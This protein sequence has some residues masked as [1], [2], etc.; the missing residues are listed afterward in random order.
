[1]SN[2][3]QPTQIE[4]MG[5]IVVIGM[6]VF[7]IIAPM[8]IEFIKFLVIVGVIGGIGYVAFKILHDPLWTERFERW[9]NLG[10]EENE[11]N[12]P[13]SEYEQAALQSPKIDQLSQ[14]LNQVKDQVLDLN[15]ENERLKGREKEI[16]RETLDTYGKQIVQQQGQ[17]ILNDLFGDTAPDRYDRSTEHEKQEYLQRRKQEEEELS[18]QR[19]ELNFDRKLHDL[20]QDVYQR[21]Q[22][23]QEEVYALRQVV[24]DGF[25]A[26]AR[27]FLGIQQEI[28]SLKGYVTEKFAQF[29][30]MLVREIMSVKELVVGLELRVNNE[31]GN[32]KVQ[33]GRE[34]VRLDQQQLQMLGKLQQFNTTVDSFR[35]DM[36]RLRM[37]AERFEM[38][39]QDMLNKVITVNERH[40]A[41]M[42]V[43]SNE[44]AVGLQKM[45]LHDQHFAAKVGQA[46]VMLQEKSNDITFALKDMAYE[47]I[48]INALRDDYQSRDALAQE[49][50]A[51]KQ[52]EISNIRQTIQLEQ[53]H[54]RDT[55]QLQHRLNMASQQQSHLQ[56]MASMMQ[57]EHSIIRRLS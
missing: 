28:T 1:M 13:M 49:R 44:L 48:G 14:E 56:N 30:T 57:K 25:T 22:S 52:Q 43:Q 2:E 18:L 6:I 54:N 33:F 34:V 35:N 50:L 41:A 36:R 31:I 17:R 53:R 46:R 11:D 8:L 42:T 21:T 24:M 15:S 32:M 39:G 29:E 37:D 40:K 23:T 19:I 51:R 45:A 27:E 38:R 47:R 10:A 4:N 5:C 20:S 9:F 26:I 55:S 7:A 3:R 16:I 12:S